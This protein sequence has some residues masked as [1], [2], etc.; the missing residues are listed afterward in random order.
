VPPG[1]AEGLASAI[2]RVLADPDL[3]RRLGT[4]GRERARGFSAGGSARLHG[5][6]FLRMAAERRRGA[7]AGRGGR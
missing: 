4:A 2:G 1:D 6:L 7:P 5:E 3:A